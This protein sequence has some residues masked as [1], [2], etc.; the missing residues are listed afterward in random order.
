MDLR[1]YDTRAHDLDS[2]YE[3]VQPGFS[4]PHGVARTS[5][6]TLFP[7]R[8]RARRRRR[9]RTHAKLAQQP[10]LLAAPPEHMHSTGVFGIWSLPDRSTAAKNA[11]EDQLDAAFDFYHKEVEQRHWYGFW[12]FGDVMHQHDGAAPRVAL[13]CRRLRLGQ[14]RT[15]HR[16]VALVQLPAHRPR[17]RLPHG[18]GHD[19]PHQRGRHLSPGPLRACSARATTCATGAAAPRKRASARPRTA[20]STTT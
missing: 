10:P 19:A 18:R 15:R 14:H 9:P 5:E 3:D 20:A 7:T 11:L 6:M 16:P 1:H 13:R 8:R 2:S 17:R 4:T 12:N